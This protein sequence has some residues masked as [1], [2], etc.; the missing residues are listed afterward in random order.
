MDPRRIEEDG[1]I[2]ASIHPASDTIV[3]M[4]MKQSTNTLDG[5]SE[6]I[7]LRLPNGDLVLG[8]FPQGD[9]YMACEEDARYPLD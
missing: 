2:L 4:V 6:W 5:R 9:T 7:W 3:K 1:I 8:V